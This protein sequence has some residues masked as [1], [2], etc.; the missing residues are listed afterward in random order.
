MI[1]RSRVL[2]SGG[3]IWF[4]HAVVTAHGYISQME[5][6]QVSPA[7]PTLLQDI[8]VRRGLQPI[9]W[10]YSLQQ[11]SK[12]VAQSCPEEH[13]YHRPGVLLHH[14]LE[15]DCISD[16]VMT[17][18]HGRA[19]GSF[20]KVT[21][22]TYAA[23]QV[24]WNM[25]ALGG[26]GWASCKEKGR[27]VVCS[28]SPAL[29]LPTHYWLGTEGLPHPA[30]QTP[31][32]SDPPRER[33]SHGK[34]YE[35]VH[36]PPPP[37]HP[38]AGLHFRGVHV[39]VVRSPPPPDTNIPKEAEY[40]PCMLRVGGSGPATGS[41][42]KRE[43]APSAPPVDTGLP[44]FKPLESMET[45]Q[46]SR[47]LPSSPPPDAWG[48][49]LG[50]IAKTKGIRDEAL[51]YHILPKPPPPDSKR[52]SFIPLSARPPQHGTKIVHSPPPPDNHFTSVI[53][54]RGES[55]DPERDA[56]LSP[57]PPDTWAAGSAPLRLDPSI[58]AGDPT[59]S[60][61]PPDGGSPYAPLLKDPGG[62]SGDRR[63]T[64][65]GTEDPNVMPLPS[66]LPCGGT[67]SLFGSTQPWTISGQVGSSSR[68]S[69]PLG[70]G[71]LMSPPP[72][73]MH[74]LRLPPSPPPI[75]FMA[76]PQPHSDEG[77]L[78]PPPPD[79]QTAEARL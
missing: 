45:R 16:A 31:P 47:G 38:M 8:R 73:D 36:Q 27:L 56:I 32:S 37:D 57:P 59:P 28:F 61:P 12:L 26:C 51:G 78:S 14:T 29:P 46:D 44:L 66:D 76:L 15:T 68:G 72:P 53:P 35:P 11:S 17:W 50:A 33:R 77:L 25:T 4:V 52:P 55:G 40:A 67:Y 3:V 49:S 9:E 39:Q 79:M 30:Q 13:A 18:L 1:L 65:Q 69:A 60:P 70:T 6:M 74:N 62:F 24:L 34:Q 2:V 21:P 71:L 63:P 58:R 5:S 19:V 54:L 10:D 22:S 43:F 7:F 48:G 64:S 75:P 20:D 23:Q 42:G 41:H